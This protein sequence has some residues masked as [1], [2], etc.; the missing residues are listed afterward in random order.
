MEDPESR[1][2]FVER[3]RFVHEILPFSLLE[4]VVMTN[5][6]HLLL[7]P[8]TEDLTVPKILERIKTQFA[9]QELQRLR[10]SGIETARFWLPGWRIRPQHLLR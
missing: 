1:D 8:K 10:A 4:W 5:H 3:L 7:R 6:V 2:R 9:R